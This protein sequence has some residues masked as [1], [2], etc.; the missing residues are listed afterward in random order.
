VTR[1]FRFRMFEVTQESGTPQPSGITTDESAMPEYE[2]VCVSGDETD[3]GEGSGPLEDADELAR[4]MAEH[5]RDTGHQ[6]Y[7]RAY[8]EYALVEPGAWL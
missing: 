4:W 7:R 1:T 3:C 5:T 2:A 6:R 8:C